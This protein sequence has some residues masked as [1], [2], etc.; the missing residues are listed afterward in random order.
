MLQVDLDATDF[1]IE[2]FVAQR[3]SEVGRVI[4]VRIHRS[5]FL[6]ALIDMARWEQARELASRFGGSGF[7]TW[8]IVR[9]EQ[10]MNKAISLSHAAHNL[11]ERRQPGDRRQLGD[12]RSQGAV[13]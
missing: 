6:L 1:E 10:V 5:P 8:A 12:C 9:L 2:Q 3:S 4:S 13:N 11:H 7:D